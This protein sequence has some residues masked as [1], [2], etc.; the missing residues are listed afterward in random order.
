[1]KKKSVL[2]CVI[3]VVSIVGISLGFFF[4]NKQN[5][6]KNYQK[7]AWKALDEKSK[8][9]I[10]GTMHDGE[11]KNETINGQH[12]IYI[13]YHAKDEGTLGPITV[14]INPDTKKSEGISV[15]K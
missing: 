12:K 2:I 9:E 13:S 1:M 10:I 11:V 3:A 15:R 5:S 8:A 14:I 6:I 4:F 7:I